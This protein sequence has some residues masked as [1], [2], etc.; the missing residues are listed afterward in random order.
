MYPEAT[1][2][3]D[4]ACGLF[5]AARRGRAL[6]RLGATRGGERAVLTSHPEACVGEGG[7]LGPDWD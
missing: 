4:T 6:A 3:L 5:L 2:Q 1:G 7:G